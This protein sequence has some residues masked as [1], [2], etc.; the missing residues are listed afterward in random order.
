MIQKKG[1][2]QNLIYDLKKDS[3][4]YKL[5]P[6]ELV[7]FLFTHG[8][9]ISHDVGKKSLNNFQKAVYLNLKSE[10]VIFLKDTE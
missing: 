3:K 2:F 9:R 1:G 8:G 6:Q 10:K 7:E 4:K 5:S